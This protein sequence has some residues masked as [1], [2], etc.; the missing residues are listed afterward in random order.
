MMIEG[1]IQVL[2]QGTANQTDIPIMGHDIGDYNNI[3]F[4]QWLDEIIKVNKSNKKSLR[5][6]F[7]REFRFQLCS[8]IF[9]SVFKRKKYQFVRAFCYNK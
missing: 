2:G 4:E 7:D 6:N 1:D 3:T 5:R 8:G 9:M